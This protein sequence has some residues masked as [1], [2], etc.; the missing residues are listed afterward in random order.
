MIKKLEKMET[1]YNIQ[2]MQTFQAGG[3]ANGVKE[4]NVFLDE[5]VYECEYIYI[6]FKCDY[7]IQNLGLSVQ[8]PNQLSN[9]KQA[10]TVVNITNKDIRASFRAEVEQKLEE[11]WGDNYEQER[12]FDEIAKIKTKR[13][14]DSL[15]NNVNFINRNIDQAHAQDDLRQMQRNQRAM[16]S[17][18]IEDAATRRD[19][20]MAQNLQRWQFE[21]IKWDLY[22]AKCEQI[23]DEYADFKKVQVKIMWWLQIVLRHLAVEKMKFNF[24]ANIQ[25]VELAHRKEQMQGLIKLSY[26]R[27]I[28][29]MGRAYEFRICNKVRQ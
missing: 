20:L 7:G 25:A 4:D 1:I 6:S 8:F 23:E 10:L 21:M 2:K 5:D 19:L 26:L 17:E 11:L 15:K 14:K 27:H 12:Y 29:R 28:K 16:I 18:K 24:E 13:A 3:Q 22:R 9:L